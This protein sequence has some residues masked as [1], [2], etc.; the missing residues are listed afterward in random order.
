[1]TLN[2]FFAVLTISQRKVEI[3]EVIF[4]P[5]FSYT[6]F[7]KIVILFYKMMTLFYKMVTLFYNMLTL[8]YNMLTLFLKW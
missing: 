7:Y 5:I 8:F 4:P 3:Y 1:M 2:N 6:L